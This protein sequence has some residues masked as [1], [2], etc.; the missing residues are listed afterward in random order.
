MM[1]S[2]LAQLLCCCGVRPRNDQAEPTV[3]PI[4]TERSRLID[5]RTPPAILNVVQD[6]NLSE[7][8]DT[9]V[10]AKEGK[11]FN[12]GIRAPFAG[13]NPRVY[14]VT[15]RSQSSL[16]SVAQ[17]A[18]EDPASSR[19]GSSDSVAVGVD[20]SPESDSEPVAEVRVFGSLLCFPAAR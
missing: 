6:Q 14:S 3:S 4:A 2:L 9:I 7:R 20:R 15:P 5:P 11:M 1:P 17:R 12:V 8:L 13:S 10:R 16:E 18:S 19:S